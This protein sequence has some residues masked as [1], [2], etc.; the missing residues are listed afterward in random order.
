MVIDQ[1]LLVEEKLNFEDGKFSQRRELTLSADFRAGRSS[2]S[3]T[4][5]TAAATSTI[6]VTPRIGNL[7]SDHLDGAPGRIREYS[8]IWS[9]QLSLAADL[10]GA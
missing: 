4:T 7:R 8:A 9:R 6:E 5:I 10:A 1:H 2:D 3:A